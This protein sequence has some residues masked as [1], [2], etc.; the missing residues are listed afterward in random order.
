MQ[1]HEFIYKVKWCIYKVYEELGPGLL[2]SVYNFA[3]CYQLTKIGFKA[4]REVII[5]LLYHGYRLEQGYRADIVVDNK[6]IIE[7]KSVEK[8]APVHHLQLRTYL[9]LSGFPHGIL[10]NFNTNYLK[11]NMHYWNLNQILS[12]LNEK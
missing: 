11:E 7:I 12:S 3:L 4:E 9:K 8:L 2:E 6:L 1:D 5:P 10:V